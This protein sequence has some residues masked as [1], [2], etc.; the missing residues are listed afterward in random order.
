M[1]GW[2]E[3][4]WY[5]LYEV[6]R[7]S[8]RLGRPDDEV[9]AACLH[10]Y[11]ARPS[12]AESLSFLASYLREHGRHA[13]AY[14]FAKVASETPRPDDI[15]F[16]DDSVYAWRALDELA[17]AAYW[18]GHHREALA[19]GQRLLSGGALPESERARVQKNMA[20]SREKLPRRG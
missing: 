3:E 11:E 13:A 17:V 5:S 8:G 20:F 9:V 14:P 1:G 10:A 15:L 16:I 18:T 2:A 12:R 6:A 7:L 19:A 4:V